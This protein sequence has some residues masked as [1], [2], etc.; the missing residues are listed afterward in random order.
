MTE[1]TV[2]LWFLTLPKVNKHSD[3]NMHSSHATLIHRARSLL[4]KDELDKAMRYRQPLARMHAIYIRAFLRVTL[5]RYAAIKPHEWCFEYGEQGKPYLS[6]AQRQ[7]TELAFNLSHS[8]EQ[9]L[10]AIT[11]TADQE[12]ELGVDIEFE[13][14]HLSVSTIMKNYF[15]PL[16][17]TALTQLEFGDQRR[18][19]FDLW[20][21]KESYIKA[22]GK[23]L[24]HALRSFGFDFSFSHKQQLSLVNENDES[25]HSLELITGIVLDVLSSRAEDD[26]NKNVKKQ[27]E[28][29]TWSTYLGRLSAACRF[30]L[31]VKGRK[32]EPSSIH[33]R[34]ICLE[35][36]L[37]K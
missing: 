7:Q 15:H 10:L 13:R 30:G 28:T 5:S 36:V 20:V 33:A 32:L 29:I 17:I 18:R 25:E 8:D 3:A 14:E 11:Q 26:K 16:E 9:V 22:T 37:A 19:F 31:V 34:Q 23:G 2:D 6:R 12:I 21:L 27:I 35:D 24:A 4:S 1:N